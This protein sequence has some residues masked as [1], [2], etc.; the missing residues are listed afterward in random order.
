MGIEDGQERAGVI[1][2]TL[3]CPQITPGFGLKL[4]NNP[5]VDMGQGL[6]QCIAELYEQTHRLDS[7]ALHLEPGT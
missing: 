5:H 2:P 6:L 4:V 1:V 7:C 3:Q